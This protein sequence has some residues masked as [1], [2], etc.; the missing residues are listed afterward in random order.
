[1]RKIGVHPFRTLNHTYVEQRRPVDT[2]A[3]LE[4]IVKEKGNTWVGELLTE[5]RQDRL[6]GH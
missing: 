5:F 1:M 3:E 2:L 6:H 4:E